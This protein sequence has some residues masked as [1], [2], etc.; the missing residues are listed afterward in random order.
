LHY[1]MDYDLWVRMA[2][3]GA[4]IVHIPDTLAIYRMH[5]GQKTSGEEVPYLP[6]L[7]QVSGEH[8]KGLR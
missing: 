8:R 3:A 1:S 4:T 6:E 2:R 7:L 5:E